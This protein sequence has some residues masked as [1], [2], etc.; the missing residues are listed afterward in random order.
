VLSCL[1]RGHEAYNASLMG[2]RTFGP[3]GKPPKRKLRALG[4]FF[5]IFATIVQD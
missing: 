4:T 3:H 1:P 5:D 2:E